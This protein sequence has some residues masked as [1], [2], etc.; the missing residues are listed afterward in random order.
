LDI[1]KRKVNFTET[2]ARHDIG[3]VRLSIDASELDEVTEVVEVSTI[4][5][6]IDRKVINVGKDLTIAGIT[7]SELLNNVQSV[8]VGSQ[9]GSINLIENK[10][11]RIL[12]DGK[13]TNIS[14][15]EL[16]K[17]IPSSSIKALALITNPSTK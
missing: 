1:Q 5:Q 10:N 8:S 7:A 2:I 17:K 12:I 16:L 11:V 14:A 9:T 6:K 4:I 3:T 15:A 13:P